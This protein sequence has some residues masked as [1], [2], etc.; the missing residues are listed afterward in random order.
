MMRIRQAAVLVVAAAMAAGCATGGGGSSESAAPAA[1]AE[2]APKTEMTVSAPSPWAGI[3]EAV[4]VVQGV[5]D[6]KV[7]GTVHFTETADGVLVTAEITGLKA[8]ARHAF[9]IHE[10]GDLTGAEGKAAGGHYN[11]EGH[12]HA[13]PDAPMHH[14]GDLGNLET[15]AHGH[16]HYE[17]LLAG[18]TIAGDHDPILGRS[19]V[20]HA[21]E[22]DLT[23]Q[24]TG[25]AGGRIG[26]GVIGIAKP[27]EA[28]KP[29]K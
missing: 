8:K 15:D 3:T 1:A 27:P 25:N 24:P 17:K 23:T 28:A 18:I 5:G 2:S 9:H 10:F 14:A 20:I 19:V 7:K 6:S 26:V 21:S 4:A 16:A 22:D 11:P 29:A 12:Q 13:G